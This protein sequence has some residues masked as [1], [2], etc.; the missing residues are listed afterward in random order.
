VIAVPNTTDGVEI[1]ASPVG[2]IA[3]NTRLGI[4]LA[5]SVVIIVYSTCSATTTLVP[6]LDVS[7]VAVISM[8]AVIAAPLRG[9][10]RVLV[11]EYNRSPI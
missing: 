10:K 11:A 9:G 2:M 7:E 8:V 6:T 5:G 3:L 4:V 1:K